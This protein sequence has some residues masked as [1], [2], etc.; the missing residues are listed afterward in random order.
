MK[1]KKGSFSGRIGF[2]MAA[3]GSAVGVGNLW[4]FPYLAAKYG[5][6]I[7]IL[8]YILLSITF[9]F[10]LMLMEIAIGRKTKSSCMSA[11]K[12]LN[13]KF[14][15]LGPLSAL[16]PILILPYYCVIGGWVIKYLFEYISGNGLALINDAYF[17]NLITVQNGSLLEN[18][19]TWFFIFIV[20]T[21]IIVMFGV[22]KG[23]ESVS[24]VM[25]PI[26][27]VISIAIAL[28]SLTIPGA[29]DGVKYYLIPDFSKFSISTIIGACGQMFFSLSLAM[30]IMITYGSYVNDDD[31]LEKSVSQIELIDTGVALLAG[32]M[33]IPPFVAFNGGDVSNIIAGP[34][35]MFEVLPKVFNFMPFGG[36]V[37]LL[38]F[39]L[40]F[41]ATLTS[42]I[43][44]L[45]TCQDILADQFKLSRKAA[46]GIIFVFSCILGSLCCLG[47]GSLDFIKIFNLAF[48]DFFDVLTNS[49][50]MPIVAL[51]SCIFVGHILGLDVI[52]QEVEKSGH[53]FKR[54]KLVYIMIKYI[55]P[56]LLASILIA[57]LLKNLGI[58]VI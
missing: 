38:F 22:Q 37:G 39:I 17:T 35:L 4:R 7:F 1:E 2:I 28:Y 55:A 5:G 43:S 41:F 11:Y 16:V 29:I 25:M 33:I 30:G 12:K 3:A 6:G 10:S 32:L 52:T 23:V 34:G 44:L 51:L 45:E 13:R 49:I 20:L 18:P 57:E 56:I 40:V 46:I 36:V 48:L 53:Q 47:Y 31:S 42:S 54:K 8:V 27:I 21:A 9:G 24:K 15:F 19:L 58:F 26:L 50:M 14:A